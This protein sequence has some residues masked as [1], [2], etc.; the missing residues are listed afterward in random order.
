MNIPYI[1]N[2]DESIFVEDAELIKESALVVG[3]ALGFK[4]AFDR[5]VRIKHLIYLDY[6][7]FVYQESSFTRYLMQDYL[8]RFGYKW[9]FT[10]KMAFALEGEYTTFENQFNQQSSTAIWGIGLQ[11]FLF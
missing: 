5:S 9:F 6:V 4:F 8:V 7:P 11:V 2:S 1:F 3:A 10:K